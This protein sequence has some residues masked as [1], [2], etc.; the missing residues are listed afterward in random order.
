MLSESLTRSYNWTFLGIVSLLTKKDSVLLNMPEDDFNSPQKLK[1]VVLIGPPTILLS[2]Q[3]VPK[4]GHC[5]NA[6]KN[7][8][9]IFQC[10]VDVFQN[11]SA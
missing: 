10:V 11:I 4:V 8:N 1:S 5:M 9:F 7:N 3:L 6:T 2:L